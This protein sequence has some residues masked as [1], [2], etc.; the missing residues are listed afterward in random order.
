MHES[1]PKSNT[2]HTNNQIQMLQKSCK[3]KYRSYTTSETKI[4][5]NIKIFTKTFMNTK[6]LIQIHKQNPTQNL[7]QNT[8]PDLAKAHT[9][10]YTNRTKNR[11]IL[12]HKFTKHKIVKIIQKVILGSY[13]KSY[14]K[15]Y[16]NHTPNDTQN[17]TNT[18][19][20]IL[21]KS[22]T[23]TYKFKTSYANHS[24]LTRHRKQNLT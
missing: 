12:I 23:K 19:H 6:K 13:T 3:R 14:T 4:L 21:H 11:Q 16:T 5:H 8:T 18:I 9:K 10:F 20:K 1:F 15:S 22:F 2:Y 24:N 17:L 7:T